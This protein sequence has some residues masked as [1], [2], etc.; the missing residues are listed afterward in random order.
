[1]KPGIR[2]KSFP[3]PSPKLGC[4]ENKMKF[5]VKNFFSKFEHIHGKLWL[6]SHIL[7]KSLT[8]NVIFWVA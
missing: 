2:V 7:R 4:T 3:T 5:S 6:Y 8:K 1:M